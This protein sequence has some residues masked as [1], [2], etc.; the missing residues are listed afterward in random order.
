VYRFASQ[1]LNKLKSGMTL[2]GAGKGRTVFKYT[3]SVSGLIDPGAE[4][5]YELFLQTSAV[6]NLAFEDLR[7]EST[8]TTAQL[9]AFGSGQLRG[10]GAVALTNANHVRFTRCEAT[11]FAG[12]PFVVGHPSGGADPVNTDVVFER[13]LVS[14]CYRFGLYATRCTDVQFLHNTID[15]MHPYDSNGDGIYDSEWG[16]GCNATGCGGVRFIGNHV[17]R[18]SRIGL[19]MEGGAG[20]SGV[21]AVF[22]DNVVKSCGLGNPVETGAGIWVENSS[23]PISIGNNLLI[24]NKLGVMLT[25]SVTYADITGGVIQLSASVVFPAGQPVSA[26]GAVRAQA[27]STTI[28]GV[29]VII[30]GVVASKGFIWRGRTDAAAQAL[31]IS[32]CVIEAPALFRLVDFETLGTAESFVFT[33]NTVRRMAQFLTNSGFAIRNV[34]IANNTFS[35]HS[36]ISTGN[37]VASF[38]GKVIFKGNIWSSTST[39]ADM[40]FFRH[41]AADALIFTDNI[42]EFPSLGVGSKI[43]NLTDSVVRVVVANNIINASVPKVS[44]DAANAAV[45]ITGN[46][47][48]GGGEYHVVSTRHAKMVYTGNLSG[49]ATSQVLSLAAAS[50]DTLITN[51]HASEAALTSGGTETQM[52]ENFIAGVWTP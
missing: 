5:G 37:V 28:S 52:F 44:V 29:M 4:H 3:R 32:G 6:E 11:N 39:D 9:D 30:D 48:S 15:N 2:R 45:T 21:E 40:T 26:H 43:L 47:F 10:H 14:D 1:L 38:T 42:L 8:L 50:V 49:T 23:G 33:G 41:Q 22:A 20:E 16:D 31:E 35:N 24:D 34:L 12:T 51:N 7:F 13:C 27:I 17:T 18:C 36:F 46:A 25:D 19:L